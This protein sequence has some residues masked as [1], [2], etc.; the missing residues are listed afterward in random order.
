MTKKSVFYFFY[1]ST[2][3]EEEKLATET[4]D[5]L[6]WCLEQLETIQAH[7]SVGDMAFSKVCNHRIRL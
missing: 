5:E 4:L 2:E 6:D 7:R 3:E 1:L